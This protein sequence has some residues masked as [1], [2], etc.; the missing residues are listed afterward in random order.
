MDGEVSPKIAGTVMLD[1]EAPGKDIP[2]EIMITHA[3]G[4]EEEVTLYITQYY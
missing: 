4:T 2:L 3:D 1:H